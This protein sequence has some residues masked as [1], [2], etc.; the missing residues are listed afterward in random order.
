MKFYFL[1]LVLPCIILLQFIDV[2]NP[3]GETGVGRKS[4]AKYVRIVDPD[5]VS[6]DIQETKFVSNVPARIPKPQTST[7]KVQ[8]C[9]AAQTVDVFRNSIEFLEKI[10]SIS[11]GTVVRVPLSIHDGY[12]ALYDLN[13]V[14]YVF[15]S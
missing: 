10:D 5:E 6:T 13:Q 1:G 15:N 12:Y 7:K 4:S 2:S 8:L 11:V 3:C 9:G 14:H